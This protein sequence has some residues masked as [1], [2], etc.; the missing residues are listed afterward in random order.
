MAKFVLKAEPTFKSKVGFPVAGGEPVDVLLTFKHRTKDALDEFVKS[1]I[2]KTDAEAFL[3]MVVGWELEDEF[4]KENVELLTQNHMGVGLA[5]FQKYI[6]E[7]VQ[8]RRGN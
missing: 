5:T 2:G 1:R 7:L 4:T 8:H 3:D 6:D